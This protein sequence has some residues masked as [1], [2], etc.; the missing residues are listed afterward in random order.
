M[1][2]GD[3]IVKDSLT[4]SFDTLQPLEADVQDT[5]TVSVVGTSPV[6]VVDMPKE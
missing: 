6:S 5:I 2:T 1:A 3:S 4:G